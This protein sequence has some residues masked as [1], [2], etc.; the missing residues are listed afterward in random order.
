MYPDTEHSNGTHNDC[1]VVGSKG[2]WAK[3]NLLRGTSVDLPGSGT[4][5]D[6]PQIQASGY[7]F[8]QCV[9]V[10]YTGTQ[11]NAT[12]IVEENWMYGANAHISYIDGLDITTTATVRNN[13]HYRE[14]FVGSTSSGYWIRY[15]PRGVPGSSD[16]SQRLAAYPTSGE[17]WVNGPYSG[18]L[19]AT[20][21]DLGI[22][23]G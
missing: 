22:S 21:R 9:L 1:L 17:R 20:P 18:N 15:N 7:S 16:P 10:T 6:H 14:V 23:V 13:Q 2:V 19:L 3:G 5:P 4:N 11:P 8:G 12:T